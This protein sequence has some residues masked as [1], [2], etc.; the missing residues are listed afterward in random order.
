[1]HVQFGARCATASERHLK[2][3]K[4]AA[5]RYQRPNK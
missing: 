5:L 4:I 3:A 1:M 2:L